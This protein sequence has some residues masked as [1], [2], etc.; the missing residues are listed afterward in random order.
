[1]S[2]FWEYS[3]RVYHY[4]KVSNILL[5][6][7]ND[8]EL[9]ISIILYA[10]WLGEQSVLLHTHDFLAILQDYQLKDLRQIVRYFRNIRIDIKQQIS[11]SDLYNR[12]Y[13]LIKRFELEGERLIHKILE[14]EFYGNISLEKTPNMAKAMPDTAH[15]QKHNLNCYFQLHASKKQ[16]YAPIKNND[17]SNLTTPNNIDYFIKCCSHNNYITT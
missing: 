12:L 13:Y 17:Q 14:S 7:Q 3:L 4:P 9:N 6:L 2:A 16:E 10:M 15:V 5:K 1:M 8:Y 11:S